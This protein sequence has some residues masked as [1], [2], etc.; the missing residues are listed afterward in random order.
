MAWHIDPVLN[1]PVQCSS[2]ACRVTSLAHHF[3]QRSEA[4]EAIAIDSAFSTLPNPN[5]L[6][7]RACRS[8]RTGLL[9]LESFFT[10]ALG[11]LV[12]LTVEEH[13]TYSVGGLFIGGRE[14][15]LAR[16][17]GVGEATLNN[18]AKLSLNTAVRDFDEELWPSANVLSLHQSIALASTDEDIVA[19]G[20]LALSLM[21][22]T[23]NHRAY[24]G[25]TAS[26]VE[27]A[28]TIGSGYAVACAEL[29]R[30]SSILY[31]ANLIEDESY[32]ANRA[33]FVAKAFGELV[34]AHV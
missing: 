26:G 11:E 7:F 27:I 8:E 15:G 33:R 24:S 34:A 29:N 31:E 16:V 4:R 23:G 5:E 10:N 19:P 14:Y 25:Q 3:D 1:R 32:D 30:S 2:E 17:D 13:S 18:C 20:K 12:I 6:V 22:A 28:V 9:F 21:N